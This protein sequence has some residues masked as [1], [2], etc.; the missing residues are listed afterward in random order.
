MVR[1]R[2]GLA[3]LL[4]ASALARADEISPEECAV[5]G[6]LDFSEAVGA[7]VR[8]NAAVVPG[9]ATLP[10]R[11][12]VAGTVAP[13]VGI[14]A[15][16]PV[17][18]WNGKLFMAGC[19]GLCGVIRADQ[20]EDAAARGYATVTTDMGHSEAKYPG[21]SWAY[22][23]PEL[24][25]D[26]AYRATHVTVVLAKEL[27]RAYY[28]SRAEHSYFRGCST[29]GRQ[30]LVAAQRFPDDFDGIIAGA[31]FHQ[32]LSVPH[33]IWA[34]RANTAPDGTPIL[35]REQFELLHRAALT[36]CD[37][38]D[39]LTDGLI[40]DP[41]ACGFTPESLLCRG[42]PAAA[43]LSRAQVDA[44]LKIYRGPVNSQ[45]APLAPSGAA[46]G[47]EFAWAER[48]LG[49]AGKPPYFRFIG[50]NW[51]QYH[52]YDPDPP[53]DRGP[54]AFDFDRDPARLAPVAA[55]TGFAPDLG[56]FSASDGHLILYH[57]WAD[58]S[59]MPSHTLD[60]WQRAQAALGGPQKLAEFA[61]LF[62]LPGVMHCGGG[63]GAGDV[64][65]LT[66][67]ERW[68]EADEAP[69][70]LIGYRTRHSV[71]TLV[72]Q[73]RFPIP[74]PAAVL[75]RPIFPYPDTARYR[76]EGEPDEPGNW[77]RVSRG[78]SPAA[79]A[80]PFANPQIDPSP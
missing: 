47:S 75:V 9:D 58:E 46:P 57:G 37:T 20:M 78:Q 21:S 28:G 16:L 30:G 80:D 73:P 2:Q 66:A 65:F 40:G 52:A 35:G 43:C 50:Q 38:V 3:T 17:E 32:S 69:D 45:G 56:D 6:A 19:Y 26:F 71:P 14:E 77:V 22:N 11:C 54:P 27:V 4:V 34:D 25:R 1:L 72:R 8:L 15:W 53:Q 76:G 31:P 48:L 12:R 61:R 67:L 33:M 24:E 41:E 68:V 23:N 79:A 60:Y 18:G 13:E 64:D 49:A 29:G 51:V 63:P 7:A 62:M 55:Q 36:A 5:L 42:Q 70:M 74:A 59:L 44:A 10:A 39:G